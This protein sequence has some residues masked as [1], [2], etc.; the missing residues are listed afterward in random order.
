MAASPLTSSAALQLLLVCASWG[1][2]QVAVK[3]AGGSFDPLTQAAARSLGAGGLLLVWLWVRG[4]IGLLRAVPMRWMVLIGLLFAAEFG[5]YYSGMQYTT[6]SRG[7]LFFYT[8]PFFVALGAHLFLPGEGLTRVKLLGLCGAFL[9]L[10]LVFGDGL[11]DGARHWWGDVLILLAAALWGATTVII[12]ASPL[13]ATAPDVTLLGQLLVSGALF[14]PAAVATQGTQAVAAGVWAWLSLLYQV[15]AVAFL[16]YLVW[17]SMI[18]RYD[19]ARLSAFTFVAPLFGVVFGAVL[20]DEPIRQGM[21]AGLVLISIG[22]WTVNTQ[23]R[24]R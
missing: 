3:V 22:I 10:C 19:A 4:R 23:D 9:G 18:L 15:L 12:K 2:N 11:G 6:A 17:F 8:S 24:G 14:L 20:L 13:R 1:L 7:V 21:V 5:L 16:S